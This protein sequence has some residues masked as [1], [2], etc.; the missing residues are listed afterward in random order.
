MKRTFYLMLL[1]LLLVVFSG[2]GSKETPG[3]LIEYDVEG[4]LNYYELLDLEYYSDI[5]CS[6]EHNWDGDANTDTVDVTVNVV[7]PYGTDIF[8]GQMVYL[9][10]RASD[11]W[12][13]I[14]TEGLVDYVTEYNAAALEDTW[15]VDEYDPDDFKDYYVYTIIIDKFDTENMEVTCEYSIDYYEAIENFWGGYGE[16]NCDSVYGSGT[17]AIDYIDNYSISFTLDSNHPKWGSYYVDFNKR[18]GVSL[19]VD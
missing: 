1:M 2:C 4:H 6:F 16:Y 19:G 7:Y 9:Y 15:Y 14:R 13:L 5:N 8:E 11:N 3:T 10:D 18:D 17:Y 12:S